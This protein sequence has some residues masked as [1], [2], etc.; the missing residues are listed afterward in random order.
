MANLSK[1]L[2]ASNNIL[3]IGIFDSGIGGFSVLFDLFAKIPDAEYYYVADSAYAPY[4]PKTD[5]EITKRAFY[6][7]QLLKDK[8]CNLIVVACNTAT[9]ASIDDLRVKY[10][11]YKYV[12]VE[13]YLNSYHHLKDV[14]VK[15]MVVLTTVSTGKSERFKRLKERLDPKGLI[16]HVSLPN[17]ATY[18]ED[19]AKEGFNADLKKK[20]E[21]ELSELQGKGYSHIILG[22]THYPLVGIWISEIT[23]GECIASGPYVAKR[24]IDLTNADKFLKASDTV[25][26]YFLETKK[27][28]T[29]DNFEKLNRLNIQKKFIF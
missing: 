3:R 27:D 1:S 9:A 16:A 5:E 26:F 28:A 25:S 8:G 23:Q 19:G 20:V 15:N 22:C 2:V 18:V 14:A 4:G 10:P 21:R 12:G 17:L 24:V 13:P 7:D 11:D 29:Q 6:I